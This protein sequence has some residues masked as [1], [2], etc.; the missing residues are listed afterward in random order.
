MT[1]PPLRTLFGIE[2][3]YAISGWDLAGAPYPR[4]PI[5]TAMLAMA[6]ETMPSL[7]DFDGR[8]VFLGNGARFLI[9]A[10]QHPEMATPECL[11]PW[12]ALVYLR[13]GDRIVHQLAEAAKAACPDLA[14]V[15]V[16]R[17]NTDLGPPP[18]SWA[19]HENYHCAERDPVELEPWLIPHL[20]SRVIL[21]GAG[22]LRPGASHLEYTV[23]PRAWFL[24]R[25]TGDGTTEDR[26]IF[27]L[28]D[29]PLGDAGYRLHV[30]AGETL[31]S[32]VAN[33]LKIGTTALVVA[34]ADAGLLDARPLAVASP[35]GA[36]RRFA[37]DLTCRA[38]VDRAGG[39]PISAI[40][41]QRQYLDAA[42]AHLDRLPAWAGTVC[43]SWRSHLDQLGA[44]PRG[45]R[46]L[47][48]VAKLAL[49]EGL[50]DSVGATLG[51]GP[52]A[53]SLDG[54]GSAAIREFDA[55]FG[56]LGGRGVYDQ[57]ARRGMLGGRQVTDSEIATAMITPPRRT[58][59]WHRGAAVRE[60]SADPQRR[61][62]AECDWYTIYDPL[63]RGVADLED[64]FVGAEDEPYWIPQ[65]PLEVGP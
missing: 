13:A 20:V 8:G 65:R 36:L 61:A 53:T 43:A 18:V 48:W 39:R 52:G 64:P 10:G 63:G 7:R 50:A 47:D 16:F 51:P 28:R 15:S 45:A 35:V 31:C 38:R 60:V 6:R 33:V 25:S 30:V 56:E 2:T 17:T 59:A 34:L 58:R 49:V 11:D 37:T 26:S 19:C 5:A 29:E 62:D 32:E 57:L 41:I 4:E 9:D 27:N 3:E 54:R 21:T 12:E 14:V 42:V 22:G 40:E 1:A 23:S 55:R 44:D 46:T 24:V